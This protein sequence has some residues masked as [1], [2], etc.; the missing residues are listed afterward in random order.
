MSAT[1]KLTATKGPHSGKVFEFDRH[2]MFIFGRA[3]DCHCAV[4]DDPYISAHHFLLEAN[5]PEVELR[6]LGSKN[7][8]FVNDVAAGRR[9]RG[10]AAEEAAGRASAVRLRDGDVVRAG[11][12]E[13]KVGIVEPQA[14]AKPEVAPKKQPNEFDR[15]LE[16][17]LKPSPDDSLPK[18]PGYAVEKLLH[19]GGMGR[20]YLGRRDVDGTAVVLKLVK[21]SIR[22]PTEQQARQ[23]QREMRVTMSLEH[24]NIVRFIDDGQA[25]GRFFFAMEFCE[26]GSVRELMARAGGKLEPGRA[27][28]IALQ[29]LAGLEYAHAQGF[30][31]RDLKPDNI[32][33]AGKGEG[34]AKLADFGLAKTFALAGMSGMTASG[35]SGGTLQFMPKEQLMDYRA[36]KPVSD[37]FSMGA[38]LYNMLTGSFIYDFSGADPCAAILRDKIVPIA[39]R[40][41]RLPSALISAIDR[42]TAP[43]AAERYATAA[44]FRKALEG[45]GAQS[46]MGPNTG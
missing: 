27:C 2:D 17:L 19:E 44:E 21:P 31:H 24:P 35:Q 23:F 37:V 45:A 8:T 15:F 34:T 30:V 18:I 4:A 36:S 26:Q 13:F 39:K 3:P 22:R 7:G 46:S 5:P 12:T 9:E 20:A 29:S 16:G 40:G 11:V 38:S 32:L 43:E 10:Q 28:R 25:E 6:D 33:I 14:E 42:A 1:V 41:A